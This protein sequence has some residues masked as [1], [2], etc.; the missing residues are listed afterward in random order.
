MKK[1]SNEEKTDD[2]FED[3]EFLK[4]FEELLCSLERQLDKILPLLKEMEE[5]DTVD[6][7]TTVG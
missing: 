2:P 3:P 1:K 6:L 4:K 5:I 7:K